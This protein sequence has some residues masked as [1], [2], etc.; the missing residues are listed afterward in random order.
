[1]EQLTDKQRQ[2][3]RLAY[4]TND[5]EL[6]RKA[7]AR[8]MT[9]RYTPEFKEWANGQ[10]AVFTHPETN[11]QVRFNSL[12]SQSQKEVYRRYKGGEYQD[13]GGPAP[14]EGG[15]DDDGGDREQGAAGE[16]G[17]ERQEGGKKRQIRRRPKKKMEDAA[18]I[19]DEELSEMLPTDKLDALDGDKGNRIKDGFRNAS[20]SDLESLF[21]STEYMAENPEDDY[22]KNHWLMKTAGLSPA[23]IKKLHKQLGKKLKD[24]KGSLYGE[25]VVEVA[26]GNDLE[27]K[28]AWAVQD[29][30]EDK[31]TRGRKLSPQELF[32]RFLNHPKT[33]AETKERMKDMNLNEFM[34]MYNS[35]MDEDEEDELAFSG[36]GRQASQKDDLRLF[37]RP[38]GA[39]EAHLSQLG[40]KIVRMA[41]HSKDPEVRRKLVRRARAE[42]QS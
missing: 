25:K 7:V 21:V 27:D 12:P 38:P 37:E 30:L 34:A 9:A 24:A 16:G 33:S 32:Q 11:N 13:R 40:R 19:S 15:G 28:D 42:L 36:A 6:R 3:I 26:E 8:V 18:S 35:I 31:P 4:K 39:K 41:F 2:I 14:G 1:M 10:G 20:Y 22:S 17:E 29:F 5:P 23:E